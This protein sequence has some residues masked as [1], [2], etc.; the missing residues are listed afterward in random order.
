MDGRDRLIVRM[1]L[2]LGLRPGELFALRRNDRVSAQYLRIDESVSALAGL[3]ET[4]TAA[5]EACIWVPQSHAI[6]LD[7][8]LDAIHDRRHDAFMFP[9]RRGTPLSPN[10]FLKRVLK[11]AGERTRKQL[12]QAQATVPEGFLANFTHQ[13]LRRSCATHMQHLGSVK[14]IQGPSPTC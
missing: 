14:D 9:S 13:A 1:F 7:F 4:K 5:S 12:E 8:W 3:V 11:K 2:L 6:E 10:N